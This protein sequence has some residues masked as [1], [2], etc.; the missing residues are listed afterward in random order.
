MPMSELSAA[1]ARLEPMLGPLT[2]EPRALGGGM[3]NHNVRVVLGGEDLVVR[4]C[5]PGVE[6]LGIDRSGEDAATRRAAALGIAP[7]VVAFL[8]ADHVL[9]TR[10]VPGE[11]LGSAAVRAPD[12]LRRI[13]RALRRFHDGDALPTRFAVFDLAE[14]HLALA[15]SPPPS[16][17]ALVALGRRI[18][19]AVHGPEHAPAPCHN[20]LLCANFIAGPTGVW[21]VDWE[22][23]GMN[24]RFFDLANLAVN[25]G[26]GDAD[27]AVLLEAY[28]GG[29]PTPA[30]HAAL[31]LMRIVSDLR[32]ALWGAVQDGRSAIDFDYA[33]YAREHFER[34]E[35]SAADPRVEEWLDVAAA[36]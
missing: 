16:G 22:Y 27:E 20:D 10:F 19:A 6:V 28:F 18:E 36:A 25:N 15:R 26:L 29:P 14:R 8:P 30:R 2:G 4:L 12:M 9:V 31:K 35:R 13:A 11:T 32:E 23:A 33:T 34:L 21:I 17:A 1:V 3:T 5:S 7:E 24:D